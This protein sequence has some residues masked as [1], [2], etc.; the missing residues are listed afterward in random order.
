MKIVIL[1]LATFATLLP[2]VSGQA[3]KFAAGWKKGEFTLVDIGKDNKGIQTAAELLAS[4]KPPG[5]KKELLVG[6]SGVV[7]IIT[8]TAAKAS[9]KDGVVISEAR[10]EVGVEVRLGTEDQTATQI[11][12]DDEPVAIAAPGRVTFASLKQ[13]LSVDVMLDV[14]CADEDPDCDA[15]AETLDIDGYVAVEIGLDTTAAH[16]FNYVLPNVEVGTYNVVACFTGTGETS[17]TGDAL[18]D[19]TAA[20]AFLA[21]RSRML[22]VKQVQATTSWD[23]I[24]TT[25]K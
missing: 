12:N 7:N 25:E 13:E 14:V 6:V 21:I 5:N 17:L 8:F 9:N 10:A 22:T 15:L 11:C 20:T 18:F 19:E 23:P 16:H 2:S 1:C 3:A 4:I 24:D